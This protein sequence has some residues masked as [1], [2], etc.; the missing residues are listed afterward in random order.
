MSFFIKPDAAIIWRGPQK[1]KAIQ[2]FLSQVEW[3]SLD[4]LVMDLPPG[5]SDEP[6]TVA[7][8]IPDSDGV[9]IVTTPQDVATQDVRKSII[10]ASKMKMPVIGVIE[11][12]SGFTCPHCGENTAIFNQFGGKRLAESMQVN[13]L[14]SIPLDPDISEGGDKGE[15]FVNNPDS[16]ITK[17]FNKLVINLDKQLKDP[18]AKQLPTPV[19]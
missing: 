2:N 15:P 10:F 17:E 16:S 9:I 12:M 7:Q 5:T 3:G 19:F 6:I 8:Q 14:G 13:F 1:F 4:Y 18:N 11:N